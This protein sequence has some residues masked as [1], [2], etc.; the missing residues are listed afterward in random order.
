MDKHDT[1]LIG[2]GT[3]ENRR[4]LRSILQER[5]NLLEADNTPQ[6]LLLLSQNVGC[7]AALVLATTVPEKVDTVLLKEPS[8][9]SLLDQVPVILVGNT[10]SPRLVN[11]GFEEGAADVIPLD[12]QPY[13]MLRRIE[14][15]V[16]LHLHKQYLETMVQEQALA[17]HQSN[18]TMVDA[19]SSIIEYRS[20]ESGQHILRIRHFT[21]ILLQEVV[22]SCPEYGLDETDIASIASASALHDIGKIAIPDAILKKPGRLTK[23]EMEVMRTHSITGCHILD[24]LGHMADKEY[25]RYAHNICHYHHERWDGKGYPEGLSGEEIPI[26]AQVVGL[27]DAYDALT[28]KRVYKDAYSFPQAVNL[29]LKGDC[30]VFSPKL[31]ECFKHV[32][33][34]FEALARAYAD[35]LS[36]KSESFD[37]TLPGPRKEQENTLER[38][39][40]KYTTLVHYINGLLMEVDLNE[41]LFHLIYNP[42]PEMSWLKEVPTFSE[43]I[44]LLDE[45]ILDAEG[46]NSLVHFFRDEIRA[47]VAADLRRSTRY[48]S[49]RSKQRP[50]GDRFEVTLLRINP[51]DAQRR[52]LAVLCRR[53]EDTPQPVSPAVPIVLDSTFLCRN[54][55]GF[56]LLQL[57]RHMPHLAGYTYYELQQL[58]DGRLMELVVPEDREHL[59]R[60]FREQFTRGTQA[61]VEYRIRQKDGSIRWIINRSRLSTD[62]NGQEVLNCYLTDITESHRAYDE[63]NDRLRRYEIILA[64]TENVLFEWDIETDRVSFSDTWEKIFGFPPVQGSA[65][66]SMQSGAFFHPDDFPQLLDRIAALENGSHY[67]V[68]EV[69]IATARGRYLW[70]RFRATAVREKDGTLTRIVGVIINIDA[71]KQ[72]ERLLQDK[73]ERDALTKL[74]NKTAGRKQAEE[75]LARSSGGST[76]LIIDLDN[77]KEVN[78]RYGHLF[79]DAVLTRAAKEI[80]KLF[81]SQDIVSRIGGDEFMVL[82]RG[83][84]DRHL[85]TSRCQRL[86]NIFASAF[87]SGKNKLPLSCSIGIALSPEHGDN[88][89]ELFNHADQALYRAK[90]MGKNDY[91]FYSRDMELLPASRQCNSAVSNAIDSDVEPG[92]AEDN[93]VRYASQ[94]LYSAA[95]PDRAVNDLLTLVGRKMKVSRVYVFENSEDNRFCSNTYEWCNQGID[96]Q[97]GNLQDVS[98]ETDIPNYEDNFDEQGIFYVEDIR[99]LPQNLYDILEPQGIKSLLHCAV[100]ESGVFRGYIGFDE[101]NEGRMWTRDQIRLLQYFSETLGLYLLNRR[102]QQRAEIQADELNTI[103]DNQAGWLYII[104]PKDYTLKYCNKKTARLTPDAKP[105]NVCY[106]ALMNRSGRCPGCPAADLGS[107]SH[108]TILTDGRTGIRLLAEATPIHWQG[109]NS[110]LMSCRKLP[111]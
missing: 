103:L 62:A 13:A 41:N 45:R 97:I 64:Q 102:R 48:F 99:Q 109:E 77:F 15:I 35:G 58:F 29:I 95:D 81:R 38:V 53:A 1:I 9:L 36:P 105:G 107:E 50:E 54:D 93:L 8:A 18:Q 27:A 23:E 55:A 12:Y 59:Q 92:L 71:E 31:L 86:L 52:T 106:R 20:V 32:T 76:M 69:R 66:E 85:I 74:L 78:D 80:E 57:G 33:A 37:T 6:L 46:R 42:Y 44:S 73:A 47:F 104:D 72:A 39:H 84:S 19:L 90:A 70:C 87:R 94:K 91:C 100:R 16:D 7:I 30:G 75:Y 65:R 34:D 96:P 101:C 24:T 14:T 89:Y 17:L 51:I 22:R 4:Q 98:Y 111:E 63:L 49:F 43:L 110:C 88:Y 25:L 79:G 82:M 3:A 83:V 11:R 67:E 68:T 10:D 56:T 26:C 2:C 40:A 108:A 60:S 28:T 5:Y 61:E 21:K